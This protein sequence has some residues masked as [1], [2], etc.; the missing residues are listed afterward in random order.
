[1]LYELELYSWGQRA[2]AWG[3]SHV[4]CMTNV[5]LTC[6]VQG[7]YNADEAP[8]SRLSRANLQISQGYYAEAPLAQVTVLKPF[9]SKKRDQLRTE[10]FLLPFPEK[11]AVPG[12]DPS[13]DIASDF[14]VV[15]IDGSEASLAKVPP[16]EGQFPGAPLHKVA[17]LQSHIASRTRR[18][19]QSAPRYARARQLEELEFLRKVAA[20]VA[21]EFSSVQ[22]IVVGGCANMKHKLV[23]E[24]PPS[25]RRRISCIVNLNCGGWTGLQK[26]ASQVSLVRKE[27]LER[28]EGDIVDE[29]MRCAQATDTSYESI[30]YGE[31]ETKLALDMGAVKMLLIC[32]DYENLERW[33]AMSSSC[34]ADTTRIESTTD[35]SATFC[36]GYRIGAFLRWPMKLS[37]ESLEEI[38]SGEC[39]DVSDSEASTAPPTSI[40]NTLPWLRDAL[41]QAGFNQASAEALTIGVDVVLSCDIST[42]EER[43]SDALELLQSQDVPAE[44]LEEFCLMIGDVFSDHF[45]DGS[46]D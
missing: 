3:S 25:L 9:C 27:Q 23:A 21:Q 35:S 26:A 16:N 2:G 37:V 17:R 36:T 10:A 18:G 6:L 15:V 12:S 44:V 46:S 8:P 32:D 28:L 4:T 42:P 38:D 20:R 5:Q 1:M 45:S 14:G 19:G 34:G 24:L 29:F 40:E 43:F 13:A 41:E 31:A 11:M 33:M 30:C 22:G 7:P 39:C